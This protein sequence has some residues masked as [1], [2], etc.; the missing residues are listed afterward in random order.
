MP[1]QKLKS[2]AQFLPERQTLATL[3]EAVQH[4]RGCDLYRFATQAV[5]GEGPVRAP[6]VMIGEQPGND[7]DLQG[8]PFVGPAGKLLDRA[9]QEAG[10]Q[11]SR[12][13]LTNAVKHF[14]FEDRGKRRLHKKPRVSEVNACRP[15]LEAELALIKPKI[16]VCLGATAAHALLGPAFRSTEKRGKFFPQPSGSV[17]TA[18]VHP[19]AILRAPDDEQRRGQYRDFVAD[20]RRIRQHLARLDRP[21]TAAGWSGTNQF[22]VPGSPPPL[23]APRARTPR[24]SSG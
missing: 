2:A 17:V 7:E 11:R 3:A 6:I 14:K 18:T 19:S 4:C 24:S 20:L 8:H 9:M 16:V 22:S 15:W 1:Q 13:Y 10:I 5:F 23:A 12:V 21:L